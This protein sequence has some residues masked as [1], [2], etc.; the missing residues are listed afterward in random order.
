[1]VFGVEK[2]IV[3]RKMINGNGAADTVIWNFEEKGWV[4]NARTRF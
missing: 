1:M 2:I 3:V 4:V